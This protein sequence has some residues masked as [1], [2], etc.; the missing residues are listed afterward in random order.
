MLLKND[1]IS[2]VALKKEETNQ[3]VEDLSQELEK[4]KI[5]SKNLEIEKNSFQETLTKA[6]ESLQNLKIKVN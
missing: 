4:Y 2:F 1:L 3:K 6:K 5:I